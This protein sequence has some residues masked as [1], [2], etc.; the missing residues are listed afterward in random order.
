MADED[1]FTLALIPMLH[2][3]FVLRQALEVLPDG[4]LSTVF[5]RC[6]CIEFVPIRLTAN[7]ICELQEA[8]LIPE[9]GVGDV[10]VDD[11]LLS[12]NTM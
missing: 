2:L 12:L 4:W 6:N 9:A 8:R 5:H 3:K 11:Q 10:N 1:G 7:L